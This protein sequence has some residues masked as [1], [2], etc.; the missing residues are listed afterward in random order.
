MPAATSLELRQD[1]VE[2]HQK[3]ETFRSMV[4]DLPIAYETARHIWQ[5]W[6]KYGH[7]EPNYGACAQA[8]IRYPQVVYERAIAM[9]QAHPRWGAMVIRIHLCDEFA[10]KDVPKIRTLQSWFRQAGVNRSP[11]VR[12]KKSQ[13]TS[14]TGA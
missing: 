3:G 1:V 5:H 13:Q 4:D 12:Q 11:S 2:R 10:E 14:S 7:L 9:K 6:Q 8:G